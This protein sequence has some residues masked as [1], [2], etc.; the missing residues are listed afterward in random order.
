[1]E[2]GAFLSLP[3]PA[4]TTPGIS[5]RREELGIVICCFS[6]L[7]SRGISSAGRVVSPGEEASEERE[8]VCHQ[9]SIGEQC[10][11]RRG[12]GGRRS[13]ALAIAVKSYCRLL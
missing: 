3:A 4:R 5:G 12:G 13:S 1:M 7:Y 9:V 10:G 6:R 8:N 2:W 11:I